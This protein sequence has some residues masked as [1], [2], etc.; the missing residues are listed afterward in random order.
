MM[1]PVPFV[2]SP[3][4]IFLYTRGL[5]LSLDPDIVAALDDDFDFEDPDNAL[6]DDFVLKAME[7]GED[8]S[9]EDDEEDG[10]ETDDSER[11]AGG[12]SEDEEGDEVPYLN[13]YPCRYVVGKFF[14]WFYLLEILTRPAGDG[15]Y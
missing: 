4:I 9:G 15:K 7:E 13:T 1:Y 3:Q 12:R 6:E 2:N 5:D 11:M 14:S 8:G 10:W